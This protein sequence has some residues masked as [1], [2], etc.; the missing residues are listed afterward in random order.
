[1][2]PKGPRMFMFS[3]RSQTWEQHSSDL[4]WSLPKG[5]LFPSH[6]C[7]P[8]SAS[9]QPSSLA[10]GP[11]RPLKGFPTPLWSRPD[12]KLSP[13]SS[14]HLSL[15]NKRA[16]SEH[17][18]LH[19]KGKSIQD[20]RRRFFLHHLIAKSTHSRNQSYLGGVPQL[21][22]CSQHQEPP[23][24]IWVWWWGKYLTCETNKVETYK[25]QPLKTP[26]QEKEK[27]AWKTQGAGEEETANS[28][29]LA[30]SGVPGTGLEEDYLSRHLRN[31]AGA[32]THGAP[33]PSPPCAPSTV[34]RLHSALACTDLD[35]P[36]CASVH[37]A[38]LTKSLQNQDG[39]EYCLP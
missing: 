30:D 15:L 28:A 27:Q 12:I 22:A 8:C 16:V 2:G 13:S 1:M 3:T 38:T 36:I 20:L 25:E 24:P 14:L 19:D 9:L 18:L 5:W 33:A 23:R 17:Q 11:I 10:C 6:L 37:R 39:S 7:S 26:R 21:Q 34:W 32:S 4:G 31:N 35:P 29:G